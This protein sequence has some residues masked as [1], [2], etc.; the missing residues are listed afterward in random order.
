M[1]L[2]FNRDISNT[3]YHEDR[4]F[5]SSSG[6]KLMYKDPRDYYATYVLNEP[7]MKMNQS[8]L[9]F[10]SYVHALILE[11]HLVD[12]QFAIYEGQTRYG[13]AWEAFKEEHKDK[14]IVTGSQ[15][16]TAQQLYDNFNKSTVLLGEGD[17]KKEVPLSSF[18]TK[19]NA[20]ET[21]CVLLEDV[22]VKVRFD[23]RKEWDTYGS[24]ND[25]KT[26][27]EF[28]HTKAHAEAIIDTWNYEVSAAL[29]VDAVEQQT[30]KPHDF[31][32]TFISKK[33]GKSYMYRA[34]KQMLEVGRRKYKIAL[35]RLKKARETG[36][37]F[38]NIILEI[39]AK[40]DI[41]DRV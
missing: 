26:T 16:R 2:G 7:S 25:I 35:E 6:L 18:Y 22:P 36:K 28:A 10:G 30:G 1:K 5:V 33:D 39:D 31:Y 34:S 15:A 8:N 32:F 9:D 12:S 3:E 11:P 20:E 14:I 41:L 40:C 21:L 23:Y 27:S 17:S 38:E 24:I 29:Y 4:T 19:G 13:K 37:F